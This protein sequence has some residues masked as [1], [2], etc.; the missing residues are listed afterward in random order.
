MN[1][2]E[3]VHVDVAWLKIGFVTVNYAL[4]ATKKNYKK[5]NIS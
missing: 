3:K 1:I 5:S 2:L 4:N